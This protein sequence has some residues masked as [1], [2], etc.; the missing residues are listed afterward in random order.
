MVKKIIEDVVS[1]TKGE[2]GAAPHSISDAEKRGTLVNISVQKNS[3]TKEMEHVE[4]ALPKSLSP[5]EKTKEKTMEQSPIFEKMKQRH[6]ERESFSEEYSSG[7]KGRFAR[8]LRIG[9]VVLGL[10]AIVGAGIYGMLF[11][12]ATVTVHLKHIDVT[13]D[14]QEVI[15]KQQSPDTVPFQIMSLSS[16]QTVNLTPTGEKKVT[17]KASGKIVVYNAYGTQSQVLIK[18]TRFET[19]DGKV[20]RIDNQILVPGMKKVDG[21][22][23]PGSLEVTVYAN[24]VGP[25]YNIG[26]VDFTIPGFKGSPRFAKFYARSKTAMT[27]G[28]NGIVKTISDDDMKKAKD[29]L[30]ASLKQKLLADAQAQK[31]KGTVLYGDAMFFTFTDT[32]NDSVQSGEKEVPLTLKGSVDAVLFEEAELSRHIVQTS[33]SVSPDEQIKIGNIEKLGFVWKTPHGSTPE[34]SETLEFLLSGTANAVWE[35][36]NNALKNKLAGAEKTKFASIMAQFPGVDKSTPE[37]NVFWRNSFP[38]DS[39]KIIIK[40]VID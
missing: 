28:V 20:Y 24:E 8:N 15:A 7:K 18:N 36:D 39:E 35:I 3:Y 16:E 26:L 17:K 10:L 27:G 19:T 4:D 5:Q 31:P 6:E 22:D 29:S 37:Y 40:T 11:Y 21:K 2:A 33:V 34:K 32:I 13:L 25:E 30:T 38:T 12:T 9:A 1:L 14:N 23:V